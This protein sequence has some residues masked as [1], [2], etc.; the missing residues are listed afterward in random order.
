[1]FL[2]NE[3]IQFGQ[4]P[5]L[6]SSQLGIPQFNP[7]NISVVS[8]LIGKSIILNILPQKGHLISSF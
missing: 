1:L 7:K 3:N 8:I 2:I 5:I 4:Y 6:Y